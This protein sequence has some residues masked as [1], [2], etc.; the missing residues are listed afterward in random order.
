MYCTYGVL[1]HITDNVGIGGGSFIGRRRSSFGRRASRGNALGAA[2]PLSEV[3]DDMHGLD[4]ARGSVVTNQP[5]GDGSSTSDSDS[6]SSGHRM[7]RDNLV[8]PYW[9]EDRDLK[10]G[11]IDFLPGVEVQFWKDLIEKYLQPLI[12]DAEKEK[13]QAR[14][15]KELRNEMVFSFFM[16]NAVFVIIVYMLQSNKDV[17]YVEWPW[18]ADVNVT[19]VGPENN[20]VVEIFY[21]YLHLEPVGFSFI[22]F[23]SFILII[24]LIGMMF[25]R[26]GTISQIVS[27]TKLPICERKAKEVTD[28][29]DLSS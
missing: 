18:G 6:D 27:T 11:P 4:M 25:H 24:Q 17:I 21:D 15:L 16:L 29:G 22:I 8:N 26:W 10:N 23:F 12:K 14:G 2:A 19:Y 5:G 9:I 20:P 28:E 7:Q 3:V 1:S 13:A